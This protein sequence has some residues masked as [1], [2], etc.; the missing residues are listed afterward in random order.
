MAGN[1]YTWST[2][3]ADNDDADGDINWAEGQAPASVNNSARAVMAGV[4]GWHKDTNGTIETGGSSNAY[5][6][7]SNTSYAALATG[8]QLAFTANHSNTGAST[9]TLNALASKAIRKFTAAGESA[10]VEGDLVEKGH[11][12][13]RYDA[14]ANSASGAWILL[15]IPNERTNGTAVTFTSQTELEWSVASGINRFEVV[16]SGVSVGGTINAVLTLGDS[17]G[18]ETSGYTGSYTLTQNGAVST[19]GELSSGIPI[20][21]WG[22]TD[23][24]SSGIISFNH[25]GSN[26]WVFSGNIGI[27]GTAAF[28]NYSVSGTKTLSGALTDIFIEINDTDLLDAGIINVVTYRP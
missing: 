8:I 15:A 18:P 12:T 26:V 11:Y 9:L 27:T 22:E 17:G 24:T 6:I 14:T 3:A 19:N 2:T 5:T 16:L 4:A 7:T 25:V 10:L 23:T 20:A 21:G 1:V 28:L 13:A